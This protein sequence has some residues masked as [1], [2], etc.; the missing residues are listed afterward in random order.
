MVRFV[1]VVSRG[2]S[3]HT[4]PSCYA[5]TD[6]RRST[7]AISQLLAPD[8]QAPGQ[9]STNSPAKSSGCPEHRRNIQLFNEP[10]G[11]V[12]RRWIEQRREL[13]RL[14]AEL[15]VSHP[16]LTWSD[17][18]QSLKAEADAAIKALTP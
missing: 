17:E 10:N 18:L 5:W 16:D 12:G 8:T 2:N 13:D 9:Y 4:W 14:E 7:A 11:W 15:R 1:L 3:L 6:L